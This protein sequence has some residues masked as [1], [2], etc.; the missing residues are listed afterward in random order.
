M[1]DPYALLLEP[2]FFEKI[3]GG[4]R[5]ARLGK[6]L[7]PGKNIG[8][9]WE[10]A[11]MAATAASGAGGGGVRSRIVNG[12]LSGKTL[13][14]VMEAWGPRLAPGPDFPLLVKFLDANEDLSVQVHPSPEYAAACPGAHLKT[15]CWYVAEAAPGS[16][17]YK[18]VKPGVSRER[19][20]RGAA[21]GSIVRDLVPVSAVVGECHL[22]PSGT[23]HAL[24]AGIVVAEVQTPSDT[25]YRLF[26]WGR[27]GRDLH[28][29]EALACASLDPTPPA[30]RGNG[31]RTRLVT[32]PHFTMDEVRGSGRVGNASCAVV[33]VVAGRGSLVTG[34]EL[35]LS[36]G[37]SVVV[38]AACSAGAALR[39]AGGLIA[40]V[41]S[42]P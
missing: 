30:T 14:D 4:R 28:V 34:S 26:D 27:R 32:T 20:E 23:V 6:R 17:I 39:D 16:V 24:G 35:P 40:L 41:V 12:P 5:L 31:P 15:E 1:P 42:L 8:E 11:D 7:P 29:R 13:H 2:V 19:L 36:A 3:W 10:V 38:P 18:G 22:L 37:A 9:S 25:T 33:I 21:D